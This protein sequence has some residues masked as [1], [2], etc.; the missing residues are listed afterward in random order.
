MVMSITKPECYLEPEFLNKVW[1]DYIDINLKGKNK[2]YY[3][4][5]DYARVSRRG[6]LS[7]QFELWLW[8]HGATVRQ[9][10]GRC[11]LEFIDAENAMMFRLRFG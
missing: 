3:H 2:K 6:H 4:P 5:A 9:I 7:Q 10:N 1:V 8:E 11:H